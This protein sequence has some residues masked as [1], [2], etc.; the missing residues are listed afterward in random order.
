MAFIHDSADLRSISVVPSFFPLSSKCCGEMLAELGSD[1]TNCTL[2]EG[3]FWLYSTLILPKQQA[4]ICEVLQTKR[5]SIP[6]GMSLLVCGPAWAWTRDLQIMSRK[7]LIF[8]DLHFISFHIHTSWFPIP[9]IIFPFQI[10][11][12]VFFYFPKMC[13]NCV[14]LDLYGNIGL[15]Q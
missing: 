5:G 9:K 15:Y 4:Y 7:Y 10:I 2:P 6:L 8:S 14:Q 13:A 11:F 12:L 1:H 3:A